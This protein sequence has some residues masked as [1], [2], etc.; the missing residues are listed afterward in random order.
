MTIYY[1]YSKDINEFIPA[2]LAFIANLFIASDMISCFGINLFKRT[3]Q[4]NKPILMKII[5]SA[6]TDSKNEKRGEG[7]LMA[8]NFCN[9]QQQNPEPGNHGK[10]RHQPQ[11]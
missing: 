3:N 10:H 2:G 6:N 11:Q 7:L 5:A 8:Y 1:E 4:T 9:D